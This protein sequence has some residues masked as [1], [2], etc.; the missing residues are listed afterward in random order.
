MAATRQ[1]KAIWRGDLA[2]GSGEVSSASS[3]RFSAL[4]VSWASR[5]EDAQGRT[6]PEEL[7]AAAHASCFAMALSA[8]LG[9]KGTPPERLEVT[10]TVRFDKVGDAWT[11]ASSALDV[12]ATVHGVDE[13]AFTKIVQDAKENCPI[14]RAL[15][16]NVAITVTGKLSERSGARA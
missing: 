4:P 9:K 2:S 14:S 1:A 5:T 7:L 12:T 11:V 16:G 8:G 6:S 10:A 3:E 13:E 15:K